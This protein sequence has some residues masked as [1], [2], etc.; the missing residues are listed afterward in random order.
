MG[1]ERK[2]GCRKAK[3]E[4]AHGVVRPRGVVLPRW[5]NGKLRRHA[6]QNQFTAWLTHLKDVLKTACKMEGRR[7]LEQN[8]G[9]DEHGAWCMP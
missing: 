2:T 9:C 6:A 5:G 4:K 1:A 3:L 8:L 7:T